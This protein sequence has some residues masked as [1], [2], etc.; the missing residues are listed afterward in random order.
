MAALRYWRG[1]V[2]AVILGQRARRS[3]ALQPGEHR[4]DL[5]R[6]SRSLQVRRR[7]GRKNVIGGD[8]GAFLRA[9]AV[10]RRLRSAVRDGRSPRSS[11]EGG[12]AADSRSAVGVEQLGVNAQRRW[13]TPADHHRHGD[14]Y[15]AALPNDLGYDSDTRAAD[16]RYSWNV[17]RTTD[18]D[19][20]RIATRIPRSR[21]RTGTGL[22]VEDQTVDGG[23]VLQ[24]PA[25]ADAADS[26]LGRR[27]RDLRADAGRR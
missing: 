2:G 23:L 17:R 19:V 1:R 21:I 10:L 14:V 16:G 11:P 4:S 7:P 3:T 5:R 24:P 9:V 13:T 27:G 25:V 22:P 20:A 18:I 12:A 26:F 8:A 6:R 15:R